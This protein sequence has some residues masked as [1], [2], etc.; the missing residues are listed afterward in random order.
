MVSPHRYIAVPLDLRL[1]H[2][3]AQASLLTKRGKQIVTAEARAEVHVLGDLGD[4]AA[5]AA[6][7]QHLSLICR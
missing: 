1:I 5:S 3:A 7:A 6:E 4:R 2:L